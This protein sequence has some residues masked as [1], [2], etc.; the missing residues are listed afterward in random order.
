MKTLIITVITIVAY[1]FPLFAQNGIDEV[2]SDIE[3]N[4]LTL[5]ALRKQVEAQKIENKTGIYLRNPELEFNYLWGNP[6]EVGSRTDISI[7][8]S[9]DFP[10]AYFHKKQIVNARNDQIELDYQKQKKA[11]LLQSRLIC[12]ELIYSNAMK[13]EFNKRLH[14]AQII[15]DAYKAK[16]DK[17]EINI[18]EFNKAQL[19]HLNIRKEVEILEIERNAILSSLTLLNGG[20]N[21]QLNDYIFQSPEIPADF[22]QWYLVA[23]QKNPL[24]N[25]LKQEIEINHQQEKLNFAMSL[26]KMYT[27]YMSEKIIGQHYQ[28]VTVGISIPLWENKN[29]VKYAK[30]QTTALQNIESDNKL[31]FYHQLKNQHAKVIGLQ[32]TVYDYRDAMKIYDNS[33]YVKKALDKGEISL[34]DYMLELSFYYSSV[35]KL[36]EAELEMNKSIAELNQY[37]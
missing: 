11:I 27:G 26:P 23:E 36:L 22:E 10:T 16:F 21:I 9:F 34:T 1:C 2:L 18:I 15:A 3:K 7:T 32:L 20:I 6:S 29:T 5:A 25:W 30:A 35:D 17:G 37:L 13:S 28:G 14:N 19:N 33:V 8:Q 4:N 31:S 12:I 24:L